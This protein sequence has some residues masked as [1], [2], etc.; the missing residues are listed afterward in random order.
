MCE[1]TQFSCPRD[2]CLK[3]KKSTNNPCGRNDGPTVKAF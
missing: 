3:E 2:V 1:E